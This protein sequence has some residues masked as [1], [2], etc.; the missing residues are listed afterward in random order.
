MALAVKSPVGEL[1]LEVALRGGAP[2]EVVQ[3]MMNAL[4]PHSSFYKIM[5]LSVDHDT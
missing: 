5:V 1:P 2:T 3:A 4:R